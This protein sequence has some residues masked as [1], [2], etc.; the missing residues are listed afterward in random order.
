PAGTNAHALQDAIDAATP[1]NL[2]VL[3]QGVY[4]ENILLWK[5]LRIQGLGPGGII[6][7]HE[8]NAR[9]PE[10]PRVNVPRSVLDG[11]FFPQNATAYDGTVSGHAPYA[12]DPTFSTILRGA[13]ITVVAKSITAYDVPNLPGTQDS[14]AFNGAR[15]DG[16][17]L[18]TGRGD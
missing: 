9:D 6:G 18:Q 15:V 8:L 4:N 5:P 3:S 2:L 13:D 16:L 1:G 14:A 11:R 12:T 17:G 7:S 10:D